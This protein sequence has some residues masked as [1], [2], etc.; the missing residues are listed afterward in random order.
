MSCIN[1][2][3]PN[4]KRPSEQEIRLAAEQ[5]RRGVGLGYLSFM[6]KV[7]LALVIL[8]VLLTF[9]SCASGGAEGV[10]GAMAMVIC[11][12]FFA[13][14]FTLMNGRVKRTQ[15]FQALLDQ[16]R[17]CVSY[18][19]CTSCFIMRG[20]RHYIGQANVE[21]PNGQKQAYLRMPYETVKRM[22]FKGRFPVM[23]VQMEGETILL[24]FAV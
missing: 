8:C 5:W 21:F 7:S 12:G 1:E 17:F 4:L 20:S 6:K 22:K 24:A 14:L 18:A 10:A 15:R 16:G 2:P 13:V 11:T 3:I 19:A 23:V 9:Q